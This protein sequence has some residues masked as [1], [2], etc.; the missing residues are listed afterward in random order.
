MKFCTSMSKAV[1]SSMLTGI[2]SDPEIKLNNQPI[3][4]VESHKFLGMHWD[5]K[6]NFMVSI[7]HLRSKGKRALAQLKLVA[8]LECGGD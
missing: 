6:P 4:Y 8:G 1:H 5:T 2:H 7:N 3:P